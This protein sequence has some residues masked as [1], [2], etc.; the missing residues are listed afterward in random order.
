MLLKLNY[1]NNTTLVR[2]SKM[3]TLRRG[4]RKGFNLFEAISLEVFVN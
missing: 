1:I 2:E 4:H 3:K